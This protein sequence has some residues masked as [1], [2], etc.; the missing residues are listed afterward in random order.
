MVSIEATWRAMTRQTRSPRSTA[1]QSVADDADATLR[2]ERLGLRPYDEVRAAMLAFTRARGP[3]TADAI[4]LVEHPPV[5]TL[6][7]AGRAEHLHGD[8]GIPVVRTERGGQITYHGPGQ[9]VAYL[10]V[11]LRRR[12]IKVREFVRLI[13]DAIIET[14]AAYNLQGVRKPGAPGVYVEHDGTLQKVAALGLKIVDGR[15]FHGLSLN[16]AMDLTPYVNI[17][18]CGYPGLKSIDMA[19]LGVVAS[20][21]D[22]GERLATVLVGRIGRGQ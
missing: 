20:V 22:V 7:Q 9:L 16:V 6:G 14:L 13:E 8:V 12:A 19:S 11:D 2:I 17:D 5:Y 3:A 21:V 15:S 4:W 18:A 10:L 1:I